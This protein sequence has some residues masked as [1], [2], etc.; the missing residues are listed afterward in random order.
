MSQEVDI[1]VQ[2]SSVEQITSG[3]TTITAESIGAVPL[4]QLGKIDSA[5]LPDQAS[6]DTEVDGKITTHNS[7]TTSV[8]GIANTANLVLTNDS[9]LADS[10]QPTAHTHTKSE[11]TDFTHTHAVADVTGLQD[12]LDTKPLAGVEWTANH[13][14]T[15]PYLVGSIVFYNH[16]ESGVTISG[17]TGSQSGYNGHYL[18]ISRISGLALYRTSTGQTITQTGIYNG[19]GYLAGQFIWRLDGLGFQKWGPTP[20]GQGWGSIPAQNAV[21][22][23]SQGRV[24]KCIAQDSS[25]QAPPVGGNSFWQELGFG[26]LLPSENPKIV[27]G[28]INTQSVGNNVGGTI[29]TSNAGGSIS[30]SGGGGS[31]NTAGSGSIQFGVSGQRTTLVGSASVNMTPH[32]HTI[33]LPIGTGTIALTNDSRFTDSRNPTSHTHGNITNAG[34][35]GSTAN[36]PLITTTAGVVTTGSFGTTANSFC[37]GNDSRL[38]HSRI[39]NNTHVGE[40]ALA[41]PSLTG[42]GN[43]AIGENTLNKNNNGNNNIAVG[44]G[45]LENCDSPDANIGVGT[46]AGKTIAS[47]GS[48]IVIGHEAD[49]DESWRQRCI[50]LGRS[51]VSPA[52]DGSLAIGGTGGNAMSGLTTTTAPTGATGTWIRIWLNGLEYRIPIQRAS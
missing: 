20:W 27:A 33:T 25:Q 11:I 30:T 52:V 21:E 46:Q 45:A 28:T 12:A 3:I 24:Y 8:H 14:A 40:T 50:V 36:L 48:N 23:P 19:A 4:G 15:N 10:R 29:D 31:I 5:Y 34:A 1:V 38:S 39:G 9:R 35:V 22:T 51:A 37:Q 2:I 43:I 6:L 32:N 42:S 13:T 7:A 17:L 47:G 44:R 18:F 41:S 16:N 49:V 26:F